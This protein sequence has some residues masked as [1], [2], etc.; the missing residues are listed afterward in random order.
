MFQKYYFTVKAV[1]SAG[2]V[3]SYSDGVMVVDTGTKLS[4]ISIHDGPVCTCT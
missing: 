1:T 2:T 4:G 3:E